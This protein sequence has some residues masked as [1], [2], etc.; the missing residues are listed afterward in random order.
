M[1]LKL[2]SANCQPF[3]P[4]LNVLRRKIQLVGCGYFIFIIECLTITLRHS[5]S[6][7]RNM[8]MC[9]CLILFLYTKI[10][11]VVEIFSL[12]RTNLAYPIDTIATDVLAMQ[13]NRTST[14]V[15]LTHLPRVLYINASVN[16]VSIGLDNGLAPIWRQAII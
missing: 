7:Q 16:G 15:I 10:A 3:R 4:A 11:Q 8:N 14:T 2:L 6:F 9:F 5:E 12:Q 1:N 13:E